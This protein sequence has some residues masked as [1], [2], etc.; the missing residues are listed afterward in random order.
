[1]S[2]RKELVDCEVMSDEESWAMLSELIILS[3]T[4]NLQNGEVKLWCGLH[5]RIPWGL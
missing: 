3:L 4:H 5:V 1:M 2:L